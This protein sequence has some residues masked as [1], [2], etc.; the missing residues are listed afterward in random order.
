MKKKLSITINLLLI[1]IFSLVAIF[2]IILTTNFIKP[3][4]FEDE[5]EI[6]EES[7]EKIEKDKEESQVGNDSGNLIQ[8]Y[9]NQNMYGLVESDN[10]YI[11]KYQIIN[12]NKCLT[13]TDIETNKTDIILTGY[14]IKG[15]NLI[16]D[17]LYMIVEQYVDDKVCQMIGYIN[18]NNL[19]IT[20][21]KTTQSEEI[22]SF[23]SDGENIYYTVKNDFYIYKVDTDNAIEKLFLSN[24]KGETPFI[25]GINN[26]K[27]Y[28]VNGI[29]MCTLGIHSHKND[30]IS[31]QYCSVEQ[32]PILT[33]DKIICFQNL[34]HSR[35]DILNLD[36]TFK[37]TVLDETK[38]NSLSSR[39]ESIN[40]SCGYI[41]L[42]TNNNIYYLDKKDFKIN[43]LKEAIPKTNQMYLT[44][45]YIILEKSEYGDPEYKKIV[46]LLA[47]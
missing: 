10:K 4:V 14:E 45:E 33:K 30:I 6:S 3:P 41:F 26:G 16:K 39:I 25:L 24:K 2:A 20:T 34:A 18:T 32:Y 35:L 19:A 22:I 36:G 11:Y 37:Q 13:K 23:S 1:S 46:W 29:E 42:L 15:L 12:K 9:N 40:Y 7:T 21:L 31:T 27:I 44:D 8:H 47:S 38:I 17:N 5:K 28:Y 43:Q